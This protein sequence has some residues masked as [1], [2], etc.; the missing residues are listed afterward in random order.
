MY[1]SKKEKLAR[2]LINEGP[3]MVRKFVGYDLLSCDENYMREAIIKSYETMPDGYLNHFL[4]D[5]DLKRK[6]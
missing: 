2:L 5:N 6:M 1:N 3:E 4:I